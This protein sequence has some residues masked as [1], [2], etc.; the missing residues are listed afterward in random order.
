[1]VKKIIFIFE[2]KYGYATDK[3]YFGFNYYLSKGFELEAWSLA[4]WTFS[5]SDDDKPKNIDLSGFTIYIDNYESFMLNIN[6]VRNDSCIFLIYPYHAYNYISYIIRKS[7][8]NINKDFI[9]I[10]EYDV[11]YKYVSKSKIALF[12][13]YF[14]KKIGSLIKVIF[15]ISHG[16]KN[17][18]TNLINFSVRA[19][20]PQIYKSYVNI[21]PSK[22]SL[23]HMPC[24]KE[25]INKNNVFTHA[26]TY[27]DW[28]QASD[29]NKYGKYIVYV[30]QGLLVNDDRIRNY[31]KSLV[32]D[33]NEFY[34]SLM[35]LFNKI[36]DDYGCDVIVAVHPKA[37][38][39]GNEFGRFKMIRGE[40]NTLIKHSV[41]VIF[42]MST[43]FGQIILSKKPFLNI[44]RKEYFNYDK[45]LKK[46]Y[47]CIN[48]VLNCK[49][50]DVSN[51]DSINN[52]NEYIYNYSAESYDKFKY[53]FIV[54]RLNDNNISAFEIISSIINKY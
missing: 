42:E 38:Y 4:D 19:L 2:R 6:R 14:F 25:A 26:E 43:C 52:Y 21:I 54:D 32:S 3:K 30:D 1:M 47:A 41:L 31:H 15:S 9:N 46:L 8:K 20:G 35:T 11:Y 49:Q 22:V 13:Y 33:K 18:K 17:F 24:F 44:Y 7:I 45:S 12:I 36:R 29:I 37:M 27:D 23:Y 53:E 51:S 48:S 10:L 34:N 39:K 40:T 16:V 50:L 28:L 5:H